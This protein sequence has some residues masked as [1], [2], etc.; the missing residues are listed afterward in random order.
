MP[1]FENCAKAN[2][3]ET[4]YD[5]LL[6]TNFNPESAITL[7]SGFCLEEF[8]TKYQFLH[9]PSFLPF[10]YYVSRLGYNAVPKLYGLM[11]T[12]S[13]EQVGGL[14]LQNQPVLPL[15]GQGV[16][17]GIIDTG[18]AYDLPIFQNED[19]TT[20]LIGLWD[21]T[22]EDGYYTKEQINQALMQKDPYKAIPSR[23]ENGHGTF[24]AGIAAGKY[25]AKADF[26]GIAVDASLAVVKCRQAKEYL[27]EFYSVPEG[28]EAYS[29]I[30][31]MRG[32]K[33]LTDLAL[34]YRMPMV[35]LIGL[36]TNQGGHDGRMPSSDYFSRI[37][38]IQG[39]SIVQAAGNEGNARRHYYGRVNEERPDE[40]EI[41]VGEN[42]RGFTMELIGNALNTFY[43]GI[44][45]PTGKHITP[46]LSP[47]QEARRY[48]FLAEG[49]VVTIYDR[50]AAF[51]GGDFLVVLQFET[52]APG[53][54]KVEVLAKGDFAT[55]YH[56]W[57]PITQFV[58]SNTYFLGS[59]PFT[60][61]TSNACAVNAIT[62]GMYNHYQNALVAEASKG[63][64]RTSVVKPDFLAPGVN[65]YGP[66][67]DGSYGT[68][69]GS[70]VAAA[71]A[72]GAA[73]QLFEFGIVRGNYTYLDGLDVK[74]LL[75][76][77]ADRKPGIE[78]PNREYG[79]G[80]LNVFRS[81]QDLVG[82]R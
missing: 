18:I 63:Y 72:A 45:S 13:V 49:S 11:D 57:M 40:A 41:V 56:I 82:Q 12:T 14:T 53:I 33:Y 35:I 38:D 16:V 7:P 44:T 21:Q 62:V 15:R 31:I 55:D 50:V 42:V 66:L 17:F 26:T 22:L 60:T 54:W 68:R 74:T 61:V 58:P 73:I 78:Y 76:R 19:G 80:T 23:D 71:H 8:E 29:E 51:Q 48:P 34:S 25:D 77:G 3:D 5:F 10:S 59:N 81:Y 9:V 37:S 39:F 64:T 6:E 75:I 69:T 24:L 67:P 4:I 20:R 1:E 28:V 36:G 47:T 46:Y 30:D 52:P 32:V 2:G 43:V 79:Y 27:R 65:V 70:S